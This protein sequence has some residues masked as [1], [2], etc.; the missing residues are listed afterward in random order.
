M[1]DRVHRSLDGELDPQALSAEE[2]LQLASGAAAVDEAVRALRSI[3]APDL[4]ARVMAA[5]PEACAEAP[6]MAD[7][8]RE[9]VGWLWSP[10]PA[11]FAWRPAYAFAAIALT[12]V[13]GGYLWELRDAAPAVAVV[14]A[15]VSPAIMFVQ[16]RLEAPGA[17]TVQVAGSFTNWTARVNLVETTPGIWS[18]LVP[19][20]PGVHDYTFIVDDQVWV[21][22]P[23]AP[24]VEDGFGGSNSRLFL[25]N[26]QESA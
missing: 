6:S 3:T 10:R 25:T 15:E 1:D 22:D 9:L 23:N 14:G 12:L 17:S 7:R 8:A 18:A 20:E 2:R 4:T 13:A 26:P 11:S 5:L 21:L 24:A 19:L 16:F